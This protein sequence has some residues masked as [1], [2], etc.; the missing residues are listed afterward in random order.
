VPKL[1]DIRK[2]PTQIDT[3]TFR[4]P[5]VVGSLVFEQMT[6]RLVDLHEITRSAHS[7]WFTEEPIQIA[8][9]GSVP[10]ILVVED[11]DFFR[12]QLMNFLE[13]EGYQV[14]GSEDGALAWNT[15]QTPG[16]DFDLVV[17]DIEMPNM[18]GLELDKRFATI[19]AS[20]KCRS[21]P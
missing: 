9:D 6:V 20:A 12:K 5:G 13:S 19:R 21:S 10:R 15:L 11:S 16:E 18:D 14:K 17:T 3:A 4:Q 2:V 7:E 8:E 1:L